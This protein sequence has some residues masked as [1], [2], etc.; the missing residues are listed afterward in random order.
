MKAARRTKTS[1]WWRKSVGQPV[2]L[3]DEYPRKATAIS[4]SSADSF[5]SEGENSPRMGSIQWFAM[6]SK[7]NVSSPHA[8]KKVW[9]VGHHLLNTSWRGS[10]SL[11]MPQL[12]EIRMD[13]WMP[14]FRRLS[15]NSESKIS[16]STQ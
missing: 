14:A 15:Q 1:L 8:K 6:S 12:C 9:M 5:M 2:I 7:V 11:N 13:Q 3:V 10:V 16:K 4:S